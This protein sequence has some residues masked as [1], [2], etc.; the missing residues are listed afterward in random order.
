M[1]LDRIKMQRG[2]KYP[3]DYLPLT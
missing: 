2:N 1:D 3:A